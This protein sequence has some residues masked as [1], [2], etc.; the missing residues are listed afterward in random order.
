MNGATRDPFAVDEARW[1]GALTLDWG[2]A[3]LS[4]HETLILQGLADQWV[5]LYMVD[6]AGGAFTAERI[7][8]APAL[9]AGSLEGLASAMRADFFRWITR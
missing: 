6:Y 5:G 7:D 8:K 1:L 9:T 3:G 4:P 2:A